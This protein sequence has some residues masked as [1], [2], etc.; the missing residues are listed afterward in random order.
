MSEQHAEVWDGAAATFDESADHGLRDPEIRSAWAA[1][2]T[3]VLPA[4][5]S[6][7]ADLGCGTGSLTI[8]AAELGHDVDGIDFSEQML[9]VA[10]SK[11]GTRAGVRFVTGDAA[12][13]PLVERVYDAVLCRHVLWALPDPAT[14]LSAW[15]K[16]LRPG[17]RL[18]LIEGSW[19]TGVGLTRQQ[20]AAL[21][22]RQGLTPVIEPL[23][24][25]RYWGGPVSDDRYVATARMGAQPPQDVVSV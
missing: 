5:P 13:P 21:L 4:P 6:R 2:L 8:L 3:R 16:L 25:P 7:L 14:V 17:G 24:D 11:A 20:T 12:S 1:L 9:T 10:R 23:S 22:R 19:S 15:T 18:V